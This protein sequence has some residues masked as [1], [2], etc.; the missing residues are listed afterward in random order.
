MTSTF[1]KL[2]ARRMP[3]LPGRFRSGS[4]GSLIAVA[5]LVAAP[6]LTLLATPWLSRLTTVHLVVLAFFVLAGLVF[7][8][9]PRGLATSRTWIVAYLLLQFP[10][11]ATFLVGSPKEPPPIYALYLPGSGLDQQLVL[12]LAQSALGLL[13]L[14]VVYRAV[15]ARRAAGQRPSFEVRMA[16]PRV[17]ALLGIGLLLLPVELYLSSGKSTAGGDFILGMPGL[18][19]SGAAA[20]VWYAFVREPRRHLQLFLLASIYGGCRVLLLSSKLTLLA[21]IVAA[22]IGVSGRSRPERS[23]LS[24]SARGLVAV[25]AA[26]LVAAYIF[27]AAIP[28]GREGGVPASVAL[29]TMAAVSRSYGVD[30][31]V[32][33][34][35]HLASGGHQLHGESLTEIVY[36]WVPRTLWPQKPKSFSVRFGEQ[37]F[38]FSSLAGISYFAPTYSGEWLLNFGVVGLVVGWLLL[39]MGLA[40]VDALRSVPHRLPWLIVAVHLLEGSL[41]AQFWLAA[42]F[43]LGG[44]LALR[45]LESAEKQAT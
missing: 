38:S 9:T 23:G 20:S 11:R 29:G 25:V 40:R 31:V 44:Y 16:T 34:N 33:V 21:C 22:V 45:P 10:V 3:W 24:R 14:M 6:L 28:K 41:V 13:V 5:A 32:A 36:S 26:G 17:Y 37:V 39:G 35:A 1:P 42:P 4:A 19:A 2:A 7:A 27:A 8:M 30:S 18:M 12:A 15:I 43:V